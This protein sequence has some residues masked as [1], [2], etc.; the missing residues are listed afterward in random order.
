MAIKPPASRIRP[1]L[2]AGPRRELR[3]S[4]ALLNRPVLHLPRRD[5]AISRIESV[6]RD[7]YGN[8]ETIA[9]PLFHRKHEYL[10]VTF[11]L[12]AL[13][14]KKIITRYRVPFST[15]GTN[16]RCKARRSRRWGNFLGKLTNRQENYP[17]VGRGEEEGGGGEC[18]PGIRDER[19]TRGFSAEKSLGKLRRPTRRA[20]IHLAAI[21]AEL[22]NRA[23]SRL[24]NTNERL[25]SWRY[26][27]RP[28]LRP[29]FAR[30][31][32]P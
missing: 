6:H 32:F 22:R 28:L 10:I 8:A 1:S 26:A 19:A 31:P 24:I 23:S 13:I 29:I 5:N 11:A 15:G 2:L 16:R 3:R 21:S 12:K 14:D 17:S 7:K 9:V 27:S 20:T 30:P 4:R 25:D 18:E